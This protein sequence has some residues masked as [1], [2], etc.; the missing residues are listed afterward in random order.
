MIL[1]RYCQHRDLIELRGGRTIGIGELVDAMI[2]RC[3][4]CA[5]FSS[6]E[7]SR[8]TCGCDDRDEACEKFNKSLT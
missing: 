3:D 4:L 5:L 6:E 1:Q 8:C 7:R 2:D